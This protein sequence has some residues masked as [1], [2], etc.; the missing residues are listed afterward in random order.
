M[1]I[2]MNM[3]RTQPG[4]LDQVRT[5]IRNKFAHCMLLAAIT[6]SLPQAQAQTIPLVIEAGSVD[7]AQTHVLNGDGR[8][9]P[10]GQEQPRIIGERNILF[11]ANF[12][13]N[14]AGIANARLSAWLT[15]F[16]AQNQKTTI[17]LASPL[18][19]TTFPTS[20]DAAPAKFVHSFN[21][22]YSATIPATWV[23]PG[24][25]WELSWAILGTDGKA[26]GSRSMHSGALR[27]GPPH[28][29]AL[30]MIDVQ[31]FQPEVPFKGPTNELLD[32]MRQKLPISSLDL[33]RSIDNV[34]PQIAMP[35]LLGKP[36]QIVST[37]ADWK[38][39]YG[40]G[41]VKRASAWAVAL[42]KAAGV[43][44]RDMVNFCVIN[45]FVGAK[46]GEGNDDYFCAVQAG[47]DGLFWH[48]FGHSFRLPHWGEG[49]VYPY[50]DPDN[51]GP[52]TYTNYLGLSTVATGPDGAIYRNTHAGPYWAFDD[53][54]T[55]NAT[56]T[57]IAPWVDGNN[58][59]TPDHWRADPMQGGGARHAK[60]PFRLAAFSDYSIN[61]INERLD[62]KVS[63]FSAKNAWI[64]DADW[65]AKGAGW[66]SSSSNGYK[67]FTTDGTL[68]PLGP[69][70]DVF[71]ILLA[72][73]M[74]SN[75]PAVPFTLVYPVIGPYKSNVRKLYNP[76]TE[77]AALAAS[78]RCPAG[79]CDLTLRV[80]Q[81]GVTSHYALEV[82]WDT[83]KPS[84]NLSSFFETAINVPARS[85]SVTSV[86]P[87]TK[88]ELLLTPNVGVLGVPAS[89]IVLKTLDVAGPAYQLTSS[90]QATLG[91][92][93]GG[94]PSELLVQN[95]GFE[96][97]FTCPSN[98]LLSGID[99]SHDN[100]N[101]RGL[102]FS[103][104]QLNANGTLGAPVPLTGPTTFGDMTRTRAQITCPPHL[105]S[106]VRG[107]GQALVNKIGLICGTISG[108]MSGAPEFNNSAVGGDWGDFIESKCPAGNVVTGVKLVT[109]DIGL[110]QGVVVDD[111]KLMCSGIQ[112]GT[113][114][115]PA[116]QA[117]KLAAAI[118][119]R[120]MATCELGP[121]YSQLM[122]LASMEVD[123]KQGFFR[124]TF[125]LRRVDPLPASCYSDNGTLAP[126]FS[127]GVPT[128]STLFDGVP[129]LESEASDAFH[130]SWGTYS[131]EWVSD[132]GRV[133]AD[134]Q[135]IRTTISHSEPVLL[136]PQDSFGAEEL[137]VINM[138]VPSCWPSDNIDPWADL[139]P[140]CKE[141]IK[142]IREADGTSLEKAFYTPGG[143]LYYLTGKT[144][145]YFLNT[146]TRLP[147][148]RR[149][150]EMLEGSSPPV[151]PPLHCAITPQR[152][153]D[154]NLLYHK[155]LADRSEA[156]N[157]VAQGLWVLASIEAEYAVEALESLENIGELTDEGIKLL[158]V[159]KAAK[160]AG[161]AQGHI[162]MVYMLWDSLEALRHCNVA[163]D[164][165]SCRFQ[166]RAA[167]GFNVFLIAAPPVAGKVL[168]RYR[169]SVP[170]AEEFIDEIELTD[171]QS[172]TAAEYEAITGKSAAREGSRR[173]LKNGTIRNH[174]PEEIAPV[175]SELTRSPEPS[176]ACPIVPLPPI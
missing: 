36:P 6:C 145:A 107:R 37:L 168:A 163:P 114:N 82:D 81:G 31:W 83:T 44:Y 12:I 69:D 92:F 30:S 59:G 67:P 28:K 104:A 137:G 121:G 160:F 123:I 172:R 130:Y 133:N 96:K 78:G 15:L 17:R 9:G 170:A 5:L 47:E 173:P 135:P 18:T 113:T 136:H 151:L 158:R 48:E 68:L 58:D 88:I 26:I 49:S 63:W 39:L 10:N 154:L 90:A 132:S 51:D 76:I 99:V 162:G 34:F 55:T 91:Y 142:R 56:G 157:T 176:T 143:F 29:L 119:P 70:Q 11:K 166:Q 22:S 4:V 61:R 118:C 32:E 103:C 89:P 110:G 73:S 60:A 16:D 112:A 45:H 117:A 169:A 146:C 148:H 86:L 120:G 156:L 124:R 144:G 87:I 3:A 23:K 74:A 140:D 106:G 155:K 141:K 149:L 24:L 94:V 54:D 72:G 165:A 71:S 152:S 138:N 27:I 52:L 161:A 93:G 167:I 38:A 21:D 150:T 64:S 171:L 66:Y 98:S 79:G 101:I 50:K 116:E 53:R 43:N 100:T 2:S 164:P 19:Q 105:I 85:G 97:L 40:D 134:G 174:L 8:L 126:C 108:V 109:Y 1:I 139:P 115:D 14:Q 95:P 122:S 102:G 175:E 13:A 159:L 129:D 131:Y 125:G 42:Q 46:G 25:T 33:R 62:D 35:A 7:I 111:L 153:L 127:G 57:L 20:I 65:A 147:G 80:V 84:S 75:A 128:P 41:E 77:R